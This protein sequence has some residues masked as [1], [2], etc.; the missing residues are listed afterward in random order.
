MSKA[1]NLRGRLAERA[2]D[3]VSWTNL[4]QLLKTAGAAVLAWVLATR[5]FGLE[6]AFLAPWSALLVVNSTVFRTLSQ[7][8]Q[9]VG[10]TVAGVTIAWLVGTSI[11]LDAASLALMLLVALGLG[12]ITPLKLDG[13]AVA[14]TAV[15]VLTIGY[16]DNHHVLVERF[17]DTA[18]GIAVGLLVNLLV[19]PPLRDYSAARAIDSL[20]NDVAVLLREVGDRLHAGADLEATASWVERCL[21]LDEAIDSAWGLVRQARESGRLNPRPGARKVREPGYFDDLLRRMAQAVAEISSIA[22][23]VGHSLEEEHTW[24]TEFERRWTE[25]V[26]EAADA[27]EAADSEALLEIRRSLQRLSSDLS[28]DELSSLLWAEYGGLILN[29]RNIVTAM[30]RVAESTPVTSHAVSGHAPRITGVPAGLSR[31]R[32]RLPRSR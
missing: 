6:Q 14:S 3:P 10:A 12:K 30:G 1:A 17:L 23:S 4:I 8:V 19:W 20:N 26:L 29:L 22:R 11:G 2:H 28:T 31:G 21:D 18:V 15:I 5:V 32:L 24:E 27:V 25:L 16:T 13:T 7:G 9:Q